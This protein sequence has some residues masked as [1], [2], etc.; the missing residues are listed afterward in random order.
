MHLILTHEQADFDAIGSLKAANLLF[1]DA[2]AILPRQIN[3]NASSFVSHYAADLGFGVYQNISGK[4]IDHITLV[5]TQSLVTIKGSSE[6][7]SVEV[8]DHHPRKA[9]TNPKWVYHLDETG[10][11]TTLLVEQLRAQKINLDIATATLLLIGIYEDTGSLS[12]ASTTPRDVYAAAF[13]LEQ[14]ADLNLASAYLNPPL[15]NAQQQLYD[16][17]LRDL[18]SLEIES[19]SVLLCKANAQ[20]ITDEISS[21][22]H[23]MRDFLNP[24]GLILLVSTRQGIRLVA[25]STTD[26]IDMGQL[27]RHFGGGGHRRAASALIRPETKPDASDFSSLH[28]LAAQVE[29]IL[30]LIVIPSLRVSQIMSGR[31]LLLSPTTHVEEAQK[32]MQRYGFEGFPVVADGKVVGLLNR[33]NVDRAISHK[34]DLTVGALMLAGSISIEPEATVTKLQD[35]MAESGWGQV[36]VKDPTT[37]EV[38]G[39][40][41]R[42]D[43]I[44]AR[45]KPLQLPSQADLISALRRVIPP[46]RLALLETVAREA[47]SVGVEAYIVGGFVRDLL[48]N[49]P[50]LDFDVVIEGDAIRFARHLSQKFGGRV[51]THSRFVTAKWLIGDEESEVAEKLGI[52]LPQTGLDLP[53]SLDLITAR[54]EFYDHPAALPTV[55]RSSIKMDLHRRDFTINTLALRLDGDH[56]GQL[57]DHWGGYADLK[58]GKIRVLHALSFVDD[59]T[60]MLRAVRFSVRFNF[61]IEARTLELLHD[62]QGLIDE[63]SGAR[64]FHELSLILNEPKALAMLERL[65]ELGILAA[66][67]PALPWN[68]QVATRLELLK[69]SGELDP[70][71]HAEILRD[72]LSPRQFFGFCLW[73][74]NLTQD[75]MTAVGKRLRMQSRL[76]EDI[77]QTGRLRR[78]LPS[79]RGKPPSQIVAEL[80]KYPPVILDVLRVSTE[81][82]QEL[83]LME[84]YLSEW[85]MVKSST[86]GQTLR[87]MGIPP[88]SYYETILKALRS[89]RLDGQITN[90]EE[91]NDYL[92]RLLTTDEI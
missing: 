58:S 9:Q 91:E 34:L 27:A 21:V 11:C 81:N 36:P 19:H 41:T 22:A 63:L 23:K 32:L 77:S 66:I 49:R 47:Q 30:P 35:I 59:A 89:A 72:G 57:F 37:G 25:R 84:R 78:T 16:R 67:H 73:L 43:M 87:E 8:F 3:R 52:D 14:G 74:E 64:I 50:S 68:T 18:V 65:F 60:R 83:E 20:D 86:T 6:R 7:T 79:L 70:S 71:N 55:E 10:A 15:S 42:T 44:K 56:F 5:D 62:S 38:I 13:L 51:V 61:E 1:P 4:P 85:R 75:Q 54:T 39:I 48:L 24:D 82:E 69:P 17:L 31:P 40:V 92:Q 45:A 46:A 76:V 88:S 26:D 33:R 53:D 28:K 80:D 12:Y 90:T 29:E 2:E